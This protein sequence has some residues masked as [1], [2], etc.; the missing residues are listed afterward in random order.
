LP[1]T[2]LLFSGRKIGWTL[3]VSS[4]RGVRVKSTSC[5]NNAVSRPETASI[6]NLATGNSIVPPPDGTTCRPII[7]SVGF[8]PRTRSYR[9]A[10][11]QPGQ[12]QGLR[13]AVTEDADHAADRGAGLAVYQLRAKLDGLGLVLRRLGLKVEAEEEDACG[14]R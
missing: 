13:D 12:R 3:R 8:S 4:L 5:C 10:T 9:P 2:R 7:V 6:F 1:A 11:V 14:E